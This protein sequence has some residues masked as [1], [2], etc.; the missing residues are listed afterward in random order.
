MLW[1]NH[2]HHAGSW[3]TI[4]TQSITLTPHHSILSPAN[5][6]FLSPTSQY[7][8]YHPSPYFLLFALIPQSIIAMHCI[9][10][11]RYQLRA[12]LDSRSWKHKTPWVGFHSFCCCFSSLKIC[13]DASPLP[14][15]CFESFKSFQITGFPFANVHHFCPTTNARNKT[16]FFIRSV[17]LLS[18]KCDQYIGKEVPS[19]MKQK[20]FLDE[21]KFKLLAKLVK[22]RQ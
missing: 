15:I 21:E 2:D 9:V 7:F 11:D 8:F 17:P 13:T 16:F 1:L 3:K 14:L 22:N 10:P 12:D 6:V 4:R 5:F 20:W 19:I 18:E